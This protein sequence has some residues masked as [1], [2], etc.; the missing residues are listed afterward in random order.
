M[1][2][3]L[4]KVTVDSVTSRFVFGVH[5]GLQEGTVKRATKKAKVR[6]ERV[7]KGYESQSYVLQKNGGHFGMCAGTVAGSPV[8]ARVHES[9]GSV[10]R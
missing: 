5:S 6:S 9:Y 8:S 3:N 7:G 1:E 2:I 4:S 10:R